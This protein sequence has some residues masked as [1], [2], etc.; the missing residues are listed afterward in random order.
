MGVA[1]KSLFQCYVG[2]VALDPGVV[3]NAKGTEVSRE[4]SGAVALD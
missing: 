4:C 2:S 3:C 1:C